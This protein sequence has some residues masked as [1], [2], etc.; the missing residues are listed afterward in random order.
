MRAAVKATSRLPNWLGYQMALVG[1]LIGTVAFLDM[2]DEAHAVL[3]EC[4]EILSA[5]NQLIG[6]ILIDE[7]GHVTL[8][9]GGL[10]SA[11]RRGIAPILE[12]SLAVMRRTYYR[13][14]PEAAMRVRRRLDD[15]SLD[16]FPPTLLQ[17]A[18]LPSESRRG[19]VW[20]R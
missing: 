6:E 8:L 2:L 16:I 7:I 3:G 14:L 20:Q 9:T 5:V 10:S 17:R 19:D 4:P 18:F 1:E 13:D 12:A 11:Q 15:Y